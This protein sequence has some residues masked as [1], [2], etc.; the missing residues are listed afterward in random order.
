[1]YKDCQQIFLFTVFPQK[2]LSM[3]LHNTNKGRGKHEY[4]IVEKKGLFAPTLPFL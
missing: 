3:D 1:M 2:S 4:E